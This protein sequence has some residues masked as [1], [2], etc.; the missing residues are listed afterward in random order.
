MWSDNESPID[1]YNVQHLVSAVASTARNQRLLPVT[2]GVFGDWGS[3]KSTV[4]R[5]VK[6]QLDREEGTLCV[7]FNGWLFE[8]YEDAK[9]AIIGSILDELADKRRAVE[10]AGDLFHRLRKRVN[11]FR[12]MGWGI[13][14]YFSVKAG[15]PP[16]LDGAAMATE[17]VKTAA[18][19]ME[20]VIKEAP[21]GED[22]IRRSVREFHDDFQEL[23]KKTDV[24]TLVVFVDDLDRCLPTTVI[25]TLEAIRLFVFVART[26][27]VI[28][29]DERLVR[30]AVQTQ[31]RDLADP[32]RDLGREYLEKL[33]QVPIHVPA[34]SRAD[35]A[36]YVNL[37]FAELHLPAGEY[38]TLCQ[39]L[40]SGARASIGTEVL[41]TGGTAREA[42]GHDVPAA[43]ADDLALAAQIADVLATS[44]AG[45][46]RQTKRF[47]NA[48][49]LRLQ[50]ADARGVPLQK[51]ITAKLMLLEYYADATFRALARWQSAQDG[52]P[53]EIVELEAWRRA[54][55]AP[56]AAPTLQ[57]TEPEKPKAGGTRKTPAAK[58]EPA[59]QPSLSPHLLVYTADPWL[60]E[61]LAL[62]PQLAGVDLKPYFYFAREKVVAFQSAA[63]RL[64]PAARG[65]L[66]KLLSDSAAFRGSGAREA[67]DL[68]AADGSAVLTALGEAADREEDLEADNSAFLAMFQLVE[69]R[70]DLTPALLAY[71]AGIPVVRL[72]IATPPRVANLRRLT[73]MEEPVDGLLTTWSKVGG[74]SR[75][76]QAS[77]MMLQ[78]L[79]P[80]GGNAAS[81]DLSRR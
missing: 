52:E 49:L 79:P 71:L 13:K 8:G 3:G 61:W 24:Q 78:R 48:L 16:A 25:E 30:H 19:G 20:G 58:Q 37:L 67:R 63:A 21:E 7:Y 72:G 10:K 65:V 15:L 26:A 32:G 42:L 56:P 81:P 74:N 35:I 60:R 46:P 18:D 75:L 80:A 73:G 22:N 76:A 5:M 12:L 2:I 45:N 41:F 50:M 40:L 43:L 17:V 6:E 27:F 36:T 68:N 29:A 4:V 54:Q 62:E 34:L 57:T 64:S 70:E 53:V 59:T 66:S 44:T 69:S 23:L 38:T 11:W 28:S 1:L 39:G 14:T 31:Y 55:D 33:V 77:K 47:L 51:R 9:A